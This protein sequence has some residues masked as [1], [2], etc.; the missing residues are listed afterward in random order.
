MKST[1]QRGTVNA[2]WE[3]VTEMKRCDGNTEGCGKEIVCFFWFGFGSAYWTGNGD[4][5]W[6]QKVGSVTEAMG[7]QVEWRECGSGGLCEEKE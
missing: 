4:G 6:T 7:K 5:L 1:A 2:G 3:G